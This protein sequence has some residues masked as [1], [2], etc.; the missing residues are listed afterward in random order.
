M[1]KISDTEDEEKW[2]HPRNT[3][4]TEVCV[5]VCAAILEF[6]QLGYL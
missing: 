5:L 6:H 3:I 4:L 1:A 2:S